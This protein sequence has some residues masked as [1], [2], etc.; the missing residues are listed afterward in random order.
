MATTNINFMMNIVESYLADKTPRV[1]FE[2]DFEAEINTR[3]KKMIRE[4][5]E[6]AELFYD[7]LSADGVDA[8]RDLSDDEFKKLI[9]HQYNEVKDIAAEGFC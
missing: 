4:D 7:W 1:T 6:Y 3:Y 9:Q 5:R 2:L 8:G